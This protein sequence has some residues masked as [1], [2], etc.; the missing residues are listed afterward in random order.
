MICLILIYLQV[1]ATCKHFAA[2]DME[3]WH[4][5][6]RHA[7]DAI[8]S[9]Q[10]LA[11]FYLPPFRS[12]ARDAKVESVMCSYN[13]VN[14]IPSCA[15]SYLLE[16]ILREH[17][18]WQSTPSHWVTS[19]CGAVGDIYKQSA[20]H[21]TQTAAQAAAVALKAGTDLD[22]GSVY[23][24]HLGQAA[25]EGLYEK[26]TL[27]NALTRLYASLVRLGY[28]D[29]AADQPWRHIGWSDVATPHAQKL[30]HRA[31][32]E[33]IV[34]LK[35]D[36]V[37]PM[38]ENG[39]TVALIGPYANA[40]VK[41][42][43]NYFGPAKYIR[44]MIWGAEHHGYQV[45]YAKGTGI[46]SQSTAGFADAMSAAKDADVVIF[47]G[48]IDNSIESEGMDR[49]A[50]AWPGNQLDLIHKLSK[51]DKP[52]AVV[53][54]GGGQVDDS[55]LLSDAGVNALLWAGYPSQAGGAAV[56]DIL[57]GTVAPA[58]RLPVTQYPADYV[59]EVPM[60]DMDLRPSADNP[61]RTYRWYD[62]AVIPFGFGRHYTT[63]DV[64]WAKH[65]M[66][67]YNTAAL[68]HFHSHSH[69]GPP[70]T[71]PPA[72]PDM[73]PPGSPD[74][75]RPGPPGTPP[76]GPPDTAPFDTFT[77]DVTNTG[78]VA[79]DY[80][81]LVFLKTTDA[82]PKPYPI[83]TLVGFTRA[84]G[85]HPGETRQVAVDVTLGSLAR[86]DEQGNLVL[87]PGSYTLEVDVGHQEYPT[88]S[89]KVHG[90]QQ[91]LDHFPQRPN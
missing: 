82:G 5:H 44:T 6:S 10:N 16:T 29:P 2:Y 67:P 27:D 66:R 80:V 60:T 57:T 55:S 47:A 56:F 13:A 14:G 19:D 31:A 71:A 65:K 3:D 69:P 59:H 78:K 15:D 61:G 25:A 77:L 86:T 43:G 35:N 12:C 24:Q 68:V 87:Y 51:L 81:A 28:F 20:H 85:I 53:Q 91:T 33:G 18:N 1:I 79:S 54:F 38:P 34:L 11:E 62:N 73:A 21:Y 84:A 46:N 42:Q 75:A 9:S 76:P 58:G 48:G 26:E 74:T 88:A 32:V 36:D 70:A 22:C 45:R 50:I 8:V 23:P 64:C 52:M 40:T 7:F 49:N 39:Q 72:P 63:F 89:F 17:W 90:P 30:A 41:M 4:G 83:K 37:L